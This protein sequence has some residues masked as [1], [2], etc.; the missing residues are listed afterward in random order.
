MA[1]KM[2]EALHTLQL[3][4]SKLAFPKPFLPDHHEKR[5]GKLKEKPAK[6]QGCMFIYG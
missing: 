4:H 5:L 6:L 1:L 3:S 2:S